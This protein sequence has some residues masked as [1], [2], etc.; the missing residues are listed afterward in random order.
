[1]ARK[2][3][4]RPKSKHYMLLNGEII[5]TEDFFKWAIWRGTHQAD[6]QIGDTTFPWRVG[7]QTVEVRVSTVF[8][9]QDHSPFLKH[10]DLFETMVFGGPLDHRQWRYATLEEARLGHDEVVTLV[11]QA[12]S[13]GSES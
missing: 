3:R 10:Q 1:M 7:D 13:E 9:G 4:R 2:R 6:C 8:L 11:R 5:A 12:L